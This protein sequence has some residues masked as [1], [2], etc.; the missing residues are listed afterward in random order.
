MNCHL[1]GDEVVEVEVKVKEEM[2]VDM[3]G[4]VVIK[5]RFRKRWRWSKWERWIW[6][7]G[8]VGVAVEGVVVGRD[9][10]GGDGCGSRSAIYKFH[11][12]P[13]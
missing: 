10:E 2:E 3:V 6:I 5:W 13:S 8:S 4:E 7:Q 11:D 1:E 12:K 9:G